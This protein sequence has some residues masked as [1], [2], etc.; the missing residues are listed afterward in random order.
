MGILKPREIRHQRR[1]KGGGI[2]AGRARRGPDGRRMGW[3]SKE[4]RPK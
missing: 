2:E 3:G 1:T 4:Q